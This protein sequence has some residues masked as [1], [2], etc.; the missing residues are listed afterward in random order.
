MD[1]LSKLSQKMDVNHYLT[2][3]GVL[4]THGDG[5]SEVEAYV[6]LKK[7]R[8][9]DIDALTPNDAAELRYVGD[10]L[11]S[12]DN[13]SKLNAYFHLIKQKHKLIA[14]EDYEQAE[15]YSGAQV[16]LKDRLNPLYNSPVIL[17]LI[18]FYEKKGL[19]A[20]QAESDFELSII[21]A[22]SE[23]D[24]SDPKVDNLYASIMLIAGFKHWYHTNKSAEGFDEYSKRMG[25]HDK[26]LKLKEFKRM[27]E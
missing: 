3:E 19:T 6:N 22:N 20:K 21:E 13:S 12:L 11:L 10:K 4:Q 26:S 1:Y 9:R 16:E 27:L 17:T 24:L 23:K 5:I 7:D 15:I 18:D 25:D 8:V 14:E 2:L